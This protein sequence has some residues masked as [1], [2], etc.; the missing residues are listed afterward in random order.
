MP[1]MIDHANL[2]AVVNAVLPERYENAKSALAKCATVDECKDWADKAAALASYAKQADDPSLYNMA[3]KI[4]ARAIRRCGDLLKEIEPAKNQHDA[5]DRARAG[6]LP[7]TR[8]GVARDAG[9][10]AHQSKQALRVASVPEPEFEAAVES[11]EPP[12]VTELAERGTKHKPPPVDHLRGRDPEDFKAATHAQG[13]L[14]DMAK[15]C[16]ASPP[17]KIFRGSSPDELLAMKTDIHTVA[18]WISG[19]A[20][21]IDDAFPNMKGIVL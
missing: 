7:S 9:L 8:N 14:R 1:T 5:A 18:Q 11:P 12:T 17:A 6:T 16:A 4:K 3:V 2:P 10:S 15:M 19:M 20:A 21:L 13:E